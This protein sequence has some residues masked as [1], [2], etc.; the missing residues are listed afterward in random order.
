[1]KKLLVLFILMSLISC[2]KEEFTPSITECVITIDDA[3]RWPENTSKMLDVLEGYPV[4]F[5]CIGMDLE[6][7]PKLANRIAKEFTMANHTYDHSDMKSLKNNQITYQLLKTDSII[8]SYNNLYGKQNRLFRFPYGSASKSELDLVY[9][10]GFST[11]WW[12]ADASDW[13]SNVTLEQIKSYYINV[14][15]NAKDT[16]I[17]LFHLSDNSIEGMKWLLR[18]LERRNIKVIGLEEY[19]NK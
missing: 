6:I 8:R 15:N 5:F 17:I 13:D 16:P 9:K 10:L 7:Q 19:L 3:P 14:L 1:M 12:N 11:Q 2:S 18:E 4:T